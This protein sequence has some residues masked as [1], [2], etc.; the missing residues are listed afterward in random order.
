MEVVSVGMEMMT[1]LNQVII[2]GRTKL[3]GLAYKIAQCDLALNVKKRGNCILPISII[4]K[5]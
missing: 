3:F 5:Q 1:Y 2:V 4:T